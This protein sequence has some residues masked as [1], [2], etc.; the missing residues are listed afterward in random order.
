[1]EMHLE[2]ALNN[3]QLNLLNQRLAAQRS[4]NSQSV[5]DSFLDSGTHS[6]PFSIELDNLNKKPPTFSLADQP[7]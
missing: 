4:E 2:A 7:F 1:M 3:H 6:F 5:R